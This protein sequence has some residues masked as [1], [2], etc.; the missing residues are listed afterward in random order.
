[1]GSA[2]SRLNNASQ[3]TPYHTDT[4]DC[5][6]DLAQAN[7]ASSRRAPCPSSLLERRPGAAAATRSRAINGPRATLSSLL[8]TVTKSRPTMV[9]SSLATASTVGLNSVSDV[10]APLTALTWIPAR[11]KK[12]KFGPDWVMKDFRISADFFGSPGSELLPNLKFA[13]DFIQDGKKADDV[14]EW[15]MNYEN[16]ALEENDKNRPTLILMRKFLTDF[17]NSVRKSD[18][19]KLEIYN[20]FQSPMIVSMNDAVKLIDLGLKAADAVAAMVPRSIY[21]QKCSE[22]ENDIRKKAFLI[23]LE[24]NPSIVRFLTG[25]ERLIRPSFANENAGMKALA[26]MKEGVHFYFACLTYEVPLDFP[27]A[28]DCEK[29]LNSPEKKAD[30]H[31]M[32]TLMNEIA[33]SPQ[34]QPLGFYTRKHNVVN[35]LQVAE[36]RYYIIE[37]TLGRSKLLTPYAI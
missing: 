32:K 17:E 15:L 27:P 37:E 12:A 4:G 14:Y 11:R 25:Y 16:S 34:I 33:G 36:I 28:Q 8:S 2:L 20:A 5:K 13:V 19:A 24:E 3:T 35:P 6:A 29:E 1:M 26:A 7:L 30:R 22:E 23:T 21:P 18:K 10:L 9:L 31:T